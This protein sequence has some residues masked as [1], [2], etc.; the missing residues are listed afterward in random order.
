MSF[1]S[2]SY[3]HNA[4]NSKV[5]LLYAR[6]AQKCSSDSHNLLVCGYIEAENAPNCKVSVHNMYNFGIN[7]GEWKSSTATY[8]GPSSQDNYGIW[9]FETEKVPNPIMYSSD[10]KTGVNFEFAIKYEANSQTYW[11][12]NNW[13]NY[14]LSVGYTA[15]HPGLILNGSS[16]VLH[17][18]DCWQRDNKTYFRGSIKLRNL[19]YDKS[20]KVVYTTDNW[21][22]TKECCAVYERDY[23]STLESWIFL[24]D[25]PVDTKEIKFA[26]AYTAS[27]T[28][29]WDNNFRANYTLSVP[30]SYPSSSL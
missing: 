12:N 4:D 9:Y 2:A 3:A 14:R 19:S 11:D 13:S 23:W 17:Y 15:E 27:G 5:R 30:G 24:I 8:V 6:G 29:H 18:A 21:A 7:Y 28:T 10:F 26:I 16:V 25:A 20:V 1:A 22:T